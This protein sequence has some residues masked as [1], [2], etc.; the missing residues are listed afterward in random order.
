MDL[1]SHT[2]S[3]ILSQ[4]DYYGKNRGVSASDRNIT[5]GLFQRYEGEAKR[6]GLIAYDPIKGSNLRTAKEP[7]S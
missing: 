5:G 4:V 1:E 7:I 3:F 2:D 6:R